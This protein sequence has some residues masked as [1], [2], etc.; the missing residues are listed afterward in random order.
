MRSVKKADGVV[1]VE[2]ALLLPILLLVLFGIMSFGLAFNYWIDETHLT[3]EAARYAA[4][5]YNP[6]PDGTLQASILGQ[7]DTAELESGAT[8]CIDYPQNAD[9]S[10][11]AG[12]VGDPVR[13]TM[14]YDHT[15]IPFLGLGTV[16]IQAAATMRLEAPAAD[17][18]AECTT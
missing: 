3:R 15:F 11:S 10:G 5:D 6:G 9:G 18:E 7:A 13:A 14:T 4:V 8:V 16:T 2:F 1:L 17:V 12:Q